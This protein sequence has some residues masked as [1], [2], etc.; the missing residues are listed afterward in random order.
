MDDFFINGETKK[1]KIVRAQ[2]YAEAIDGAAKTFSNMLDEIIKRSK[3]ISESEEIKEPYQMTHEEGHKTMLMMME[4]ILATSRGLDGANRQ[5]SKRYY[6][7]IE[8]TTPEITN[9]HYGVSIN[10]GEKPE[11]PVTVKIHSVSSMPLELH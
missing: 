4:V 10:Y 7:T 8:M 1:I 6:D 5:Q 9:M 3:E 11:Q 2:A